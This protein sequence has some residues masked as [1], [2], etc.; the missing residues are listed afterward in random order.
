MHKPAND[1][2]TSCKQSRNCINGLY[3][4]ALKQYV[5]WSTSSPCTS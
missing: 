3:C 5:E 4:M 1:K 2:C